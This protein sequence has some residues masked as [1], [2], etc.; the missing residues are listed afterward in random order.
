[1]AYERKD[2][3][4]TLFK[5]EKEG[6][7]KRPDYKG[8]MKVQGVEYTFA[9]WIATDDAGNNKK[10]KNGNAFINFRIEPVEQ[11]PTYEDASRGGPTADP[12]DSDPP[13]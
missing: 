9:G 6:N 2:M 12:L 3:T 11:Q 13:F 1:M 10:D 7:D 8:Q 4:A 5:N